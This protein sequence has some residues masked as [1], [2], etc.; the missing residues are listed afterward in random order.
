MAANQDLALSTTELARA[1]AIGAA[2]VERWRQGLPDPFSPEA[3]EYL[4]VSL[5][6]GDIE[7]GQAAD[8]ATPA[9][10]GAIASIRFWLTAA[11]ALA[12][13]AVGLLVWPGSRQR[14][15]GRRGL[16]LHAELSNRTRH[17]LE[18]VAAGE[19]PSFVLVLGVPRASLGPVKA[20][21]TPF[22]GGTP[23]VRPA[24]FDS[25]LQS[26][27]RAWRALARTRELDRTCPARPRWRE[28]LALLARIVLGE[29]SAGWWGRHGCPSHITYGHTG[30]ADTTRL[31][32]A[33]QAA[34]CTTVHAVHGISGGR[35][36]IGRSDIALL[37]C[38]HDAAWHARLGG[39]G[40][41][42][43]LPA[44]TP[45]WRRGEAGMLLLSSLAHPMYLGWQLH[46][47]A[48]ES[49]LL[50][51]A[52]RAADA[53]GVAGPRWWMPHPALGTLP[54]AQ[55]QAVRDQ[56]RRLGFAAPL[57]GVHFTQ[58][59]RE[60]RWIVSSESTVVVELLADGQLPVVW[61]SPWSDPDSALARYAPRASDP[62]ELEAHLRTPD[63]ERAKAFDAAWQVVAP[64]GVTR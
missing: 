20:A 32:L 12:M 14:L 30:N 10:H 35:N 16:A 28:Q 50:D 5:G 56:A 46:G 57:P 6:R 51:A 23:M 33:Q 63:D 58:L 38:G 31:E 25:L 43:F 21:W 19:R 59:A 18:S 45:S 44:Q 55:Q 27:P 15:Q 17:V 1:R 34:G 61:R 9:G 42:E 39:Y 40:R 22:L 49:E 8:G 53:A 11:L 7:C 29:A 52:A 54:V 41:C 62:T 36:F 2:R 48:E 4:K 37:R 60:V 3:L 24:S 47:I 64:G 13:L 26:L